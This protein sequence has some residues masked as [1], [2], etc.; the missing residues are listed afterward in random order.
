MKNELRENL[1]EDF[2][3]I[4]QTGKISMMKQRGQWAAVADKTYQVFSISVKHCRDRPLKILGNYFPAL[5]YRPVQ[6][7]NYPIIF[8][9]RF[10]CC[11]TQV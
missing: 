3:K 1:S 5:N 6:E 9:C 2:T 4:I 10:Y 8:P 7:N 11:L